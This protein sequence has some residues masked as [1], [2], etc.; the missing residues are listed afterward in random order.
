MPDYYLN[1]K[2]FLGTD[3]TSDLALVSRPRKAG[4][5]FY[6]LD[7]VDIDD[8]GK[9]HRRNGYSDA[10]YNGSSIRSLWANDKI[11]LFA[12]GTHFKT[13]NSYNVVSNLIDGIDE[14]STFCYVEHG[15]LVYFASSLIIGYINTDTATP[16]PFP[17]ETQTF[18]IKM[19]GG[20]ILEFYNSRLYAANGSNLFFSD[21]TV[22]TR[23]DT[24]KNIFAFPSR[25]TMV[26]GVDDG[27]YV[28]DSNNVYFMAGRD[29]ISDFTERK[30]LDVPAIEGMSVT[31]K[32]KGKVTK[33]TIYWMTKK[34][35]Y[36]GFNEGV[37]VP[38]Q[39]GLFAVDG[40]KSGTAIIRENGTYQQLLMVGKY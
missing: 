30:V 4:I 1:I 10:I 13:I 29:P 21:A 17:T 34:G 9:P 31:A 12:D 11:C 23:M 20:Q 28:S 25:I 2:E 27:I 26:K 16:Y 38:Q 35:I 14:T 40:L 22:P 8:N 5:F 33:N 15:N 19:V 24:R 36:A 3:N 37:I 39:A 18:K 32:I 6:K 7:N